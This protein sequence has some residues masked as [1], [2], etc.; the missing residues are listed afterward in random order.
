MFRKFEGYSSLF[1]YL[2]I[3]YGVWWL[4][5]FT[6]TAYKS[7]LEPSIGALSPFHPLI[8]FLTYLPSIAGLVVYYVTGGSKAVKGIILKLIPRKQDLFLFP[9]LFAIVIL[10]FLFLRFGS[11]WLG[12]PVPEITYNI[13]QML[14]QAFNVFLK[15]TAL[16]GGVFGWVGF[17]LPFLQAKTKNN[18][19]SGLVA[20]LAFGLWLMPMPFLLGLK[21]NISYTYYLLQLMTFFVFM[22]YIF[23]FTKGTLIFYIFTFWLVATGSHMQLYYFNPSIQ[24]MQIVF[25][26]L[27]SVIVYFPFKKAKIHA[28]QIF[29]SFVLDK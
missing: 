22:S 25:F 14:S 23:N 26:A 24:I 6:L 2:I 21:I 27:V 11:R 29:P 4:G 10:F 9:V 12:F 8:I 15:E 18:I 16:V 1:L 17:L 7:S 13:P 5:I 19:F 20:G 3:A 28:L